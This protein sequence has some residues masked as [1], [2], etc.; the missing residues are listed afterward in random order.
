MTI[1]DADILNAKICA[2]D[3]EPANVLLLQRLLEQVGYRNIVTFTDSQVGFDYLT[4]HEMDLLLL[5][6]QMPRLTGIEILERLRPQ[7]EESVFTPIMILTAD[8]TTMTKRH[9]ISLGA[10][11]FLTKPFDAVEVALRVKNLI[12]TRLALKQLALLDNL[13]EQELSRRLRLQPKEEMEIVEKLGG[14]AEC[15][16][17][18]PKTHRDRVGEYSAKIAM[19]LGLS[20]DFIHDIQYAAQLYDVGKVGIPDNILLK[21]GKLTKEEFDAMKRHTE[22]GASI[23]SGSNSAIMTMAEQIAFSHHERWDGKGYPC[24]LSE[25]DI[26]LCGRIVAVVDVFVALTHDRS[27]KKAWSIESALESINEN[28]GSQF[29]PDVVDAFMKVMATESRKAA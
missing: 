11:D 25:L 12:R 28:S 10:H 26:P 27:Y 20:P 13:P 3:D 15:P 5:D 16:M 29:D 21:P 8:A 9:S 24:G 18:D 1:N 7:N 14:P 2:I 6:L 22:I 17:E 19:E 23:L 4:T